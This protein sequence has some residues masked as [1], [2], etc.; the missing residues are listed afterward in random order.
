MDLV[1]TMTEVQQTGKDIVTIY[2]DD[3]G[4]QEMDIATLMTKMNKT[5]IMLLRK[6]RKYRI[7]ICYYDDKG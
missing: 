6:Q 3:K 7:C 4:R 1:A 2:Y 5:W